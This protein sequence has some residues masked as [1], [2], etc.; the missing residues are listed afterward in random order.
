M[1]T[2]YVV[3]A[4]GAGT[5]TKELAP[6]VPKPLLRL[7]DK[8]LLEWSLE[9]L[10]LL[11][12]DELVIITQKKDKVA[13]SLSAKISN[14][15]FYTN[16]HFLEIEA[17]TS[18][19]LETALLA[20]DYIEQCDSLVVFNC[21]T[22]FRSNELQKMQA[23]GQWDGIIPCSNEP[24]DSWSFCLVGKDG[25]VEKVTEKERI[26]NS[27]SVGYYYFKDAKK[28]IN[29][30]KEYLKGLDKKNEC[31][32]AP[33]YNLLLKDGLKIAAPH[34]D[35]FYPMGSQNQI[36][37]YWKIEASEIERNN[38][39]K[40][41]VVDLDNTITIEEASTPYPEKK[42]NIPL[43]KRMHEYKDNGFQIYIYTAR[44]MR[45]HNNDV[46]KVVADIGDI[47][48]RWL[49]KHNVPYDGLV[50]GKPYAEGG[51][52]IDDKSIRPSEF[53]KYSYGEILNIIE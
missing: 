53:L 30:T 2:C 12:T 32:V 42:A 6:L 14:M 46:A 37:N 39:K 18:G 1:K 28:F 43:I 29:K 27:A 33:F 19:Q 8:T 34:V 20:Q 23:S 48:H 44:R 9:S 49:E 26:S 17:I 16:V 24:G 35:F 31:Y 11:P 5:R 36:V 22:F 7:R 38:S 50:Y 52:Y 41:I 3:C 25:K 47:T 21:D 4:A 13:A 51:F 40:V 10:D 45:T 15:F